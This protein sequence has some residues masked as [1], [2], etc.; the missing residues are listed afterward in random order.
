MGMYS[1]PSFLN[2]MAAT[3]EMDDLSETFMSM[4]NSTFQDAFTSKTYNHAITM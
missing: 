3:Q 4:C 1:G 2:L